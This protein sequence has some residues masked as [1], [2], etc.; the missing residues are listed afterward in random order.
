VIL[1][2]WAGLFGVSSSVAAHEVK[3]AVVSPA[4]IRIRIDSIGPDREWSFRNAY[5]GVLGIAERVDQFHAFGSGGEDVGARKI[6]TGE[7]RSTAVA[8]TVEYVV[9][10]PA[11]A[12]ADVAHV[13]WIGSDSGLLMLADL[14][15]ERIPGVRVEMSLPSG[16]TCQ[17]SYSPDAQGKYHV[18]E[19]EKTVFLLGRALRKQA[20]RVKGLPFDVATDG[21]WPF[22]VETVTK[23]AAKVLARYLAL[24]GSVPVVKPMV[25]LAP[26]PVATGSVKWRAETRGQ[27]VVLLMDPRAKINNWSGQ[28]GIIFTHELL[29]LWVPN[30]LLLEGDYDW[31]FEGFTLYT[32]LVTALELKFINFAEYVA[33]LT[34]VYD[35][36]LSRPDELSLIDAS[37]RRWTSGNVTVYD[38]GM[39]VALLYDLAIRRDSGGKLWLGSLYRRLFAPAPQPANGNEVIIRLLSS[40]PAGVELAKS[41]IEGRRELDI[42]SL[43]ADEKQLSKSLYYR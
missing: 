9:K 27:T 13:S 34:R 15:P 22:K 32:A 17:S 8:D 39:L 6:A 12:A 25:L 28:L 3:I 24:T 23:A 2:L 42:K 36:Y 5:A 18:V 11:P 35:S 16:W 14:L 41:Y 29:H 30:S 38:K 37:E 31:F 19:P 21:E 43:L 4:E 26:L 7:F 10:L 33:T 1:V 40:T 20:Q